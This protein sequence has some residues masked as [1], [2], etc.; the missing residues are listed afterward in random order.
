[1]LIATV[2]ISCLLRGVHGGDAEAP[3]VDAVEL[4][5]PRRFRVLSF[6]ILGARR[7][8]AGSVQ[9]QVREREVAP[10]D[11]DDPEPAVRHPRGRLQLRQIPPCVD[12]VRPIEA[13]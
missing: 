4:G 9:L 12:R 1:M 6:R 8:V 2:W 10:V 13:L 5:G 3:A 7:A 11:S